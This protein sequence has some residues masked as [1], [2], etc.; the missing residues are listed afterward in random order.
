MMIMKTGL[1]LLVSSSA[2]VV[3]AFQQRKVAGNTGGRGIVAA[4]LSVGYAPS[5]TSTIDVSET[6]QRDVYSM[7]NWAQQYGV[8][9][10]EGVQIGSGDGEDYSV[11]TNSNIRAGRY[12]R[13]F[14]QPRSAIVR[15]KDGC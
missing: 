7:Q 14:K 2:V 11:I 5:S 10:A 6:A 4:P 15:K 8:Q 3:S 1:L 12:V 13:P 9:L